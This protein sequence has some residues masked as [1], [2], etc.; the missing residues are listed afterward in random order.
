MKKWKSIE[1]GQ[2]VDS[3]MALALLGLILFL[4]LRREEL[5]Y[6]AMA[7]LVVD[8]AVPVVLKPFAFLWLNLSAVL[9]AIVSKL[10]LSVVYFGV[11]C[12]I[13]LARRLGKG[14]LD[15]RAQW[16]R[17]TESV[18]VARDKRFTFDDLERPY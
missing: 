17:S 10:T 6:G 15:G 13:G 14:G 18:L 11:V 16:R 3:G 5:L 12:P 4:A 9:G 7:A 2:I 8:M 1:R